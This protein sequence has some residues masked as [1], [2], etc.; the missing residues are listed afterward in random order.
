MPQRNFQNFEELAKA[1]APSS[2]DGQDDNAKPDKDKKP[3]KDNS[4]GDFVSRLQQLR[5]EPTD[6]SA[7]T[8]HHFQNQPDPK[9]VKAFKVLAD[10]MYSGSHVEHWLEVGAREK[11]QLKD[12]L[13]R[14]HPS[15][16]YDFQEPCLVVLPIGSLEFPE[17][18]TDYAFKGGVAR[19]ALAQRLR[20][21][22]S[23]S[24]VRDMD[25]FFH[26]IKH[27]PAVH[28]RVAKSIMQ[29]DWLNSRNPRRVIG[30]QPSLKG[31]L[32]TREFTINQLMLN[33]K[34][35]TC[36]IQSLCD[37]V[38]GVIRP[39]RFHLRTHSGYVHGIVAAKAI[40]FF[41]EGQHEGRDMHLRPI[42]AARPGITKF[43]LALHLG[44]ALEHGEEVGI[45]FVN[46]CNKRGMTKLK[47]SG[48]VKAIIHQLKKS[49]RVT[50]ALFPI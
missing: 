46:E 44:R 31:Y 33:K 45:A 14:W 5:V 6:F 2:C 17:L 20:L 29:D 50:N 37:L 8:A 35:I 30:N 3:E 41:V 19:K 10:D 48:S 4:R 38:A 15:L 22:A 7:L 27:D 11:Q 39:T 23:T 9:I 49:P 40:R 47:C 16:E 24:I 32:R 25:V 42:K 1:L 21:N 43:Q 26:G 36:T 28:K 18:P 12:L 13:E 34:E